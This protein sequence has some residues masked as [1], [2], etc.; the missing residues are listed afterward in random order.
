MEFLSFSKTKKITNFIS[1]SDKFTN[2]KELNSWLL[3]KDLEGVVGE[4]TGELTTQ[5]SQSSPLKS[6]HYHQDNSLEIIKIIKI[7]KWLEYTKI[8][9]NLKDLKDYKFLYFSLRKGNLIEIISTNNKKTNNNDFIDL[10]TFSIL[11]GYFY[12]VNF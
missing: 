4:L 6:T 1:L 12:Y 5:S 7:I 10:I 8:I 9:N 11:R 3:I 2:S